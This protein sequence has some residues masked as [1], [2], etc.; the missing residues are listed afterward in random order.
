MTTIAKLTTAWSTSVALLKDELWQVRGGT[1][2]LSTTVAP[3][4]KDGI[5]LANG[6]G[7]RLSAGLKV[8][9][10]KEGTGAPYIVREVI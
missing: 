8:R 4:P 5:A 7:L 2:C 1:V 10:R 9:S 3:G 6:D